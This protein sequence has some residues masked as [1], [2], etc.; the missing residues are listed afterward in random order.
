MIFAQFPGHLHRPLYHRHTP[1]SAWSSESP[2]DSAHSRTSWR[3]PQWWSSLSTQL[4]PLERII[5]HSKKK[6]TYL[7]GQN[8][9]MVAVWKTCLLMS[10][11]SSLVS[12]GSHDYPF[13][14]ARLSLGCSIFD[15][16]P[17]GTAHDWHQG[18]CHLR[19]GSIRDV[20]RVQACCC[21]FDF[22]LN[23]CETEVR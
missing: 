20:W 3:A 16:S 11:V 23:D 22:D 19:M 9:R 2:S 5:T 8:S 10:A 7:A 21:W 1:W 15:G 14:S 18:G 4:A 17:Q 12:F 13:T 6:I